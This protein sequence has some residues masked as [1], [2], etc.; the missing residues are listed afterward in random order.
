[1]HEELETVRAAIERATAGMKV[2]DLAWHLEGKWS[3][4]EVLE[5]L[6]LT[7]SGTAKGMRA[8]AQNDAPKVRPTT[9]KER[10]G[11]A[12]VVGVGY[13]PAGREAPRQVTPRESDPER[14]LEKIQ[15]NLSE[16]D[17]AIGECEQRFGGRAIVLVHPVLGPLSLN[18]WRKFHR[19][20]CLHHM[21][22][23]RSLRARMQTKTPQAAL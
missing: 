14:V 20:H 12:L 11:I 15:A 2:E 1:M 23:I 10:F 13:F 21:K 22:Q 3:S 18:Q 5:H 8:A 16:M 6:A 7:Y 17:K 4:A 19:V 9:W